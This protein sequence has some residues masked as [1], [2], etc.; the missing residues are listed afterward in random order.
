MVGAML[1]LAN[2][3]SLR[4]MSCKTGENVNT[5]DKEVALETSEEEKGAN[6]TSAKLMMMI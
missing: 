1:H 6:F 2:D 5:N 4:E 3:D